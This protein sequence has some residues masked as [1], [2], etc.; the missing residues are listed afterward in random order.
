MNHPPSKRDSHAGNGRILF[1]EW[2]QPRHSDDFM[3]ANQPLKRLVDY[4]ALLK[5]QQT[6]HRWVRC[7]MTLGVRQ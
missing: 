3:F 2:S 7:C 4:I 6:A 5:S 1:K